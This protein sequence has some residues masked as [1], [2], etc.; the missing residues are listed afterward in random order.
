M[1]LAIVILLIILLMLA[2]AWRSMLAM[3]GRSWSGPLPPLTESQRALAQ[4]LHRDVLAL[5]ANG[6]RIVPETLA[7]A[8][9][10]IERE[11]IAAGY[12]PSR[13]HTSEGDNIEVELRGD[14]KEIVIIGAHY[15][16]FDD[17]P[18]ADDN[19]SGVAGC[20]AMARRLAHAHPKHTLRFVFFAAE[21]PPNFKNESMGSYAY[22]KRCHERGETIAAMLSIES[23]GYYDTRP[24]SQ[25]YPA[26][27]APF[28]STTGDFIGFAGNSGSRALV[29]RCVGACR[30]RAKFPSEGAAVP[31]LVEEIGWSDQ[32]SFWQFGW[33]ALMVTDTAPFRNPHYHT[34]G[35]T[36]ETIDYER[37]ARVVDGLIGVVTTLA[38]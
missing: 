34:A 37:T 16:S 31:E 4:E 14:S 3:P 1:R 25:Q 32:W 21:E 28:F 10:Y 9:A 8:A 35:D 6:P 30:K 24:G 15:D 12:A 22:A 33:P 7:L 5:C 18:G 36:P 26:F 38:G 23:I 27:L 13:Q 2:V 19:A 11:L 17:A 20:L 29:R